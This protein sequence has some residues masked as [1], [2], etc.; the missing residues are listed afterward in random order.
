MFEG[1]AG[2]VLVEDREFGSF[3][4]CL[5]VWYG[6]LVAFVGVGR[7]CIAIKACVLVMIN[8]TLSLSYLRFELCCSTELALRSQA[9]HRSCNCEK[10]AWSRM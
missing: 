1:C 5:L 4:Q 10:D 9:Y 8:G 2:A 6:E 7:H 3:G